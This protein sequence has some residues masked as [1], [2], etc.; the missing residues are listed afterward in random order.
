MLLKVFLLSKGI[1]GCGRKVLEDEKIV[2][3]EY[4]SY[5][6]DNPQYRNDKQ[7]YDG[8]ITIEK[9]SLIEPE[10]HQRIKKI[11]GKKKLI[12][13]RIGVD[14]PLK[15]LLSSG[16]IKI[17]NCSNCWLKS[18]EGYDFIALNICSRIFREYQQDGELPEIV[19]YNV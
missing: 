1:G 15:V 19:S 12:I 7:V 2:I 5:N 4:S 8:I 10:I 14:I 18:N 17:E 6:L 9:A 13:K 3:Y 11:N 16:E